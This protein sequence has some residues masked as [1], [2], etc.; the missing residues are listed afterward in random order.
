[1]DVP[2][3]GLGF[4]YLELFRICHTRSDIKPNIQIVL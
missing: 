3:L 2:V 1:M 4:R